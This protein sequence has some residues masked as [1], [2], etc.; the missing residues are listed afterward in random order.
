MGRGGK[1]L[2]DKLKAYATTPLPHGYPPAPPAASPGHDSDRPL[3]P[4][5]VPPAESTLRHDI[6]V[7][8]TDTFKPQPGHA[9][10]SIAPVANA[11]SHT[12][13]SARNSSGKEW[14]E[15]QPRHSDD[16]PCY[17]TYKPRG[18]GPVE[19]GSS[20]AEG[21]A[22]RDGGLVPLSSG[23]R[24]HEEDDERHAPDFKRMKP[25]K[26]G[27]RAESSESTAGRS[28]TVSPPYGRSLSFGLA[29]GPRILPYPL[30]SPHMLP[31]FVAAHLCLLRQ[32]VQ[33]LDDSQYALLRQLSTSDGYLAS[34]GATRLNLRTSGLDL[35]GDRDLASG[36][37]ASGGTRSEAKGTV[38]DRGD[39]LPSMEGSEHRP[40]FLLPAY[41]YK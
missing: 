23:K 41:L 6:G 16:W 36:T 21:A 8:A 27:A 4:I 26:D 34:I 9:F 18:P 14:C 3:V 12:Y 38:A 17:W 13:I 10:R 15:P 1:C 24:A 7:V 20:A 39:G 31:S 32:R 28:R 19:S 37:R 25:D 35:V 40:G 11:F 22:A 5:A 33:V 29:D 2:A 30:S